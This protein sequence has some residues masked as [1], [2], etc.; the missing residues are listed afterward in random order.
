MLLFLTVSDEVSQLLSTNKLENGNDLK[1]F[2]SFLS[3]PLELLWGPKVVEFYA[4]SS[5]VLSEMPNLLAFMG[6]QQN[7]FPWQNRSGEIWTN[8]F[9]PPDAKNSSK[10]IE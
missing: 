9:V 1:L 4:L 6:N 10:W 7:V 3:F 8:S 2:P 5:L